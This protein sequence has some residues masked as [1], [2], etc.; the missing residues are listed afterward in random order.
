MG[1]ITWEDFLSK[2]E[3]LCF[4]VSDEPDMDALIEDKKTNDLLKTNAEAE[5]LDL[6]TEVLQK[7]PDV[8]FYRKMVGATKKDLRGLLDDC[9]IEGSEKALNSILSL[10]KLRV[11]KTDPEILKQDEIIKLLWEHPEIQNSCKIKGCGK[12][13]FLKQYENN[14]LTPRTALEDAKK[15]IASTTGATNFDLKAHVNKFA[16]HFQSKLVHSQAK[17]GGVLLGKKASR[18]TPYLCA[19]SL[20]HNGHRPDLD[21]TSNDSSGIY[22][23]LL[24]KYA[25]YKSGQTESGNVDPAVQGFVDVVEQDDVAFIEKNMDS[26]DPQLKQVIVPHP[27]NDQYIAFVPLVSPGINKIVLDAYEENR[28]QGEQRFNAGRLYNLLGYG[29]SNAQNVCLKKNIRYINSPM[30]AN[31]PQADRQDKRAWRFLLGGSD[32][33]HFRVRWGDVENYGKWLSA[34]R[35]EGMH[36]GEGDAGASRKLAKET[37]VLAQKAEASVLRPIVEEC[38]YDMRVLSENINSLITEEGPRRIL[39]EKEMTQDG[40]WEKKFLD[41]R[42]DLELFVITGMKGNETEEL[43]VDSMMNTIDKHE[44]ISFNVTDKS[45]TSQVIRGLIKEMI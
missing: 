32:S 41:S 30:L 33:F 13:D 31:T 36:Q 37:G 40:Q 8:H 18:S 45:R 29:G 35:K 42:N 20:M 43:L 14:T 23:A 17:N 26:L 44:D 39:E 19:A 34:N 25:D 12:K 1:A 6:L 5:E 15:A 10:L 22:Q 4:V 11:D 9:D 7:H 3:D 38:V 27:D 21:Q 2:F 24:K 16:V 28:K